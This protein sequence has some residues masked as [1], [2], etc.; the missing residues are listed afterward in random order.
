[1]CHSLCN[2]KHHWG[3]HLSQTCLNEPPGSGFQPSGHCNGQNS[4]TQ[5]SFDPW[6]HRDVREQLRNH[7]EGRGAG[8]GCRAGVLGRGAG[9]VQRAGVQ[10]RSTGHLC[11]AEVQGRGADPPSLAQSALVLPAASRCP[12]QVTARL[13]ETEVSEVLPAISQGMGHPV[14]FLRVFPRTCGL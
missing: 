13:R 7:Q 3:Q 12:G 8:W 1:M 10:G 11:W 14:A 5:G 9:Q 6:A 2:M 4:A